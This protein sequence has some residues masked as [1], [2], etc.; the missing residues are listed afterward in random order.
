MGEWISTCIS[1][2]GF[3]VVI[4]NPPY[5][6]KL[7]EN[8]I[9]NYR[10][11]YES[12]IGHSEVY[13]IFSE[14]AIKQLCRKGGYI[15]YIIP[16]AWLSNKYAKK[17]REILIKETSINNLINFNRK[18]IFEDANVETSI[19][20]LT[21]SKPLLENQVSVG[22]DLGVQYSFY[23]KEWLRNPNFL[24]SFASNKTIDKILKKINLSEYKLY[25][26]LDI[27]NGYKPYQ[28]NYGINLL[29][30]ALSPIDVKNRIYHSVN[31]IDDSYKKEIKGKGVKRYSLF[32]EENYIKWGKWLMSPKS[33]H[34]FLQPKILLRQVISDYLFAYLDYDKYYADQSLYVCTNFDGKNENLEYYTAL[35][36][37]RLYGFYFR[38][39]Y[40]EEDDL[41]PKIKVNELKNIP[42]KETNEG[43]KMELSKL[44]TNI[45]NLIKR[46]Q[47]SSSK[48][49]RTIQRTFDNLE[50][51]PK[52]LENWYELTFTDFVK[53]LKKKKIKLS[54]GDQSD[55]EDYFI[56]EQHKTLEIKAQITKTD[57]EI[58]AMVYELFDLTDEE[59]AIIEN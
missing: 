23:Q 37:S 49:Q 12:V 35:L 50:N 16:N 32:W 17:L 58:D 34:Y 30:S 53:E 28:A 33:E 3:D 55:W 56:K 6:A 5:G 21:N 25:Q 40:S 14:K 19:F 2:G 13:Y 39:Y 57:K 36:N 8:E 31:K 44:S 46:L 26:K 59:I 29:G 7:D 41:F 9:N 52:K 48:F 20:I 1:N 51:L 42:I 24:I 45:T 11:K 15:G 27:S 18:K 38:K 43:F 22:Q 47:E 4:G 54:P 10:N